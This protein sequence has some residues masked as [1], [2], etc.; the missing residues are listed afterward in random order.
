MK[1]NEDE[2]KARTVY[3]EDSWLACFYLRENTGFK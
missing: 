1:E 2:V 3:S